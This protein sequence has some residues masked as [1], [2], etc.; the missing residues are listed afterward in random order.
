MSVYFNTAFS[1]SMLT[2]PC[3]VSVEFLNDEEAT[4]CFA[5]GKMQNIAN[6]SHANTL[7]AVS[8]KLGVD[9]RDAKGGRVTLNKG[10]FLLVAQVTFPPD[11]PRE[12]KEY[13]DEQL[14]RGTFIWYGVMIE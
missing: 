3:N 2:E 8:Q 14:A 7:A 5:S 10:D 12:T 9:V 4:A 13:T 6:P 11:I 1:L